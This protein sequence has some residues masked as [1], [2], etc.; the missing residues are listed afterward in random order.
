MAALAQPQVPACRAQCDPTRGCTL[1]PRGPP[2]LAANEWGVAG[3]RPRA[4][5]LL[6]SATKTRINLNVGVSAS[7]VEAKRTCFSS[8]EL[9]PYLATSAASP[10]KDRPQDSRYG[11][12]PPP[13]PSLQPALTAELHHGSETC[14]YLQL[15]TK[16]LHA[17]FCLACFM[18]VTEEAGPATVR[19]SAR[20]FGSFLPVPPS[21]HACAIQMY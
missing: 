11:T 16:T 10:A 20:L 1:G 14:G 5:H 3:T 7:A 6:S 18:S 17:A 12:W 15:L 8:P 9:S 19:R 13:S 21:C 4:Y 2:R